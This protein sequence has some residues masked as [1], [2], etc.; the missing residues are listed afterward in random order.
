[1]GA[2]R[3]GQSVT[4][5]TMIENIHERATLHD[6]FEYSG[7]WWIPP[8]S[9]ELVHGSVRYDKGHDILL[10]VMEDLPQLNPDVICGTCEGILCTLLDLRYFSHSSGHGEIFRNTLSARCLL[11]GRH[12][13]NKSSARFNSVKTR[14]FDFADWAGGYPFSNA[15]D[16]QQDEALKFAFEHPEPLEMRVYGLGARLKLEHGFSYSS[17]ATFKCEY[18]AYFSV[19]PDQEQDFYWYEKVLFNLQNLLSLLRGRAVH[20]VEKLADAEESANTSDGR[21][22]EP[23]RIYTP[24]LFEKDRNAQGV[25]EVRFPAVKD[26]LGHMIEQW[27][28]IAEQYRPVY[29]ALMETILNPAPYIETQ[30][31]ALVQSLEGFHRREFS[32]CY[33]ATDQYESYMSGILAAL[34]AELPKELRAALRQRL[35]FGNEYSLRRRIKEILAAIPPVIRDPI[36]RNPEGFAADLTGLRNKLVHCPADLILDIPD[37]MLL[38]TLTMKLKALLTILLLRRIG[39]PDDALENAIR[40][41]PFAI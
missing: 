35:Q 40:L 34:P 33:V 39:I 15:F 37:V 10:T 14:L 12:F 26:R 36:C 18:H 11:V 6:S 32:G 2:P 19:L 23:I 30:F 38:S 13:E 21:P 22:W 20:V 17:G 28:E 7:R 8:H 4:L 3:A 29:G 41:M 27:F 24:S 5:V 16:C 31:L 9:G 25:L 1:M